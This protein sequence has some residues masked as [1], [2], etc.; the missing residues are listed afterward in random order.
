MT[1]LVP[2]SLQGRLF[3]GS[4]LATLVALA[5]AGWA[6]A[7]VL[8][9]FVTAGIDQR[10]DAQI[11]LLASAVA[12]DGRIDRARIA[13]RRA[14][15]EAGQGWRWRIETPRAAMASGDLPPLPPP[16]PPGPPDRPGPPDAPG[17][18]G[19]M[20]R[21][22]DHAEPLDGVS[23]HGVRLH[24]RRLAIAT[25][26]GPVVLT[27]AAPRAVIARPIRAAM[28]PLLAALAV[29]AAL[30]TLA[31][32]VQLRLGLRPL[33]RLRDAVAAM[34]TGAAE[35]VEGEQPAE[36][37]P[38]VAEL[39]ALARDNDAALATA[40][41]SAANLAHALKTPVSTLA[42]ALR[43]QPAPAAQVARI[44]ATI[45]HHL[46]RA[47]GGEGAAR[48]ATP[49]AAA[50][51]GL[52]L[53]V[54]RLYA[55]REITIEQDVAADLNVRI[56]AHDLDEMIGNLIDNA[57]RHA[58]RTVRVRAVREDRMVRVTVADDGPGIAAADRA[59]ATAAGVRLDERGDGH[60]F[61]LT[62]VRELAELHGGALV[63]A[64]SP[65][66]GLAASVTMPGAAA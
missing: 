18:P 22:F 55:A 5:L 65:S 39:N 20:H 29:L 8:E 9:R 63:L 21:P 10:L 49:L 24:A 38:L 62:I 19:D 59:R 52:T 7:G 47:R 34:R 3:A 44:D 1:R 51:A 17:P 31:S 35:R 25:A 58:R 43:D 37:A 28:L 14:A 42:L 23:D 66:G 6:I 46:S 53:A 33:R 30:L 26:A 60:G 57:A 36:L 56:D 64:A 32:W 48:V 50:V 61:G 41:L 15:L 54:E 16:G 40:R 11:A 27:A 13:A 45:R 2:R 12:P 4:A